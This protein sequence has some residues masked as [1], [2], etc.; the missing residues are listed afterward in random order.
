MTVT[1]YSRPNCAPC[2]TLFYFLDKKGIS[3]TKLS[4]EGTDITIV[5]TVVIGNERIVG[6]NFR[7]L[8][9]LL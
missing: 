7:R 8:A 1:V 6:L 9:E 3:Y 4:P 2:R 5:P